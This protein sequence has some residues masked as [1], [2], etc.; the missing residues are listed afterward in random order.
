MLKNAGL[1]TSIYN[2]IIEFAIDKVKNRVMNRVSKRILNYISKYKYNHNNED[3]PN[4][5]TRFNI[6]SH[7]NTL[8][9][10]NLLSTDFKV[11][12]SLPVST[13][14]PTPAPV[15]APASKFYPSMYK[16]KPIHYEANTPVDPLITQNYGVPCKYYDI[17]KINRKLK[18]L[19]ENIK[20]LR[21]YNNIRGF[22]VRHQVDFSKELNKK[23]KECKKE[24]KRLESKLEHTIIDRAKR[25]RC[26][27]LLEEQTDKLSRLDRLCLGDNEFII[28]KDLSV[29]LQNKLNG[30]FNNQ[31]VTK[32]R[33]YNRSKLINAKYSAVLVTGTHVRL[34]MPKITVDET[35]CTLIVNEILNNYYSDNKYVRDF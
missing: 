31:S 29:G 21:I 22:L 13:P 17:K 18:E 11:L 33:T 35:E 19:D 32:L 15:P 24:K 10:L 23:R 20:K 2:K 5:S 7:I 16:G 25:I 30:F 34:D 26:I 28:K 8:H 12:M 1:L 14:T 6:N 27:E 3:T 9:K 4:I